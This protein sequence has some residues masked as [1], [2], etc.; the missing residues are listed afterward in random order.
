MFIGISIK[1]CVSVLNLKCCIGK[2]LLCIASRHGLIIEGYGRNY[3]ND[4][5]LALY[6]PLL[7]PKE[8]FIIVVHK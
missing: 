2:A 3:P 8:S 5:K 7:L 1:V 4:T 6:K